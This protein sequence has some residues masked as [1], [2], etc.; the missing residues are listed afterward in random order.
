MTPSGGLARENQD[1]GVYLLD[2][3]R[4]FAGAS[5]YA[6][7]GFDLFLDYVHPPKPANLLVAKSVFELMTRGGILKD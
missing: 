7:P 4:I 2:L 3:D 1:H 5:Q 6:A